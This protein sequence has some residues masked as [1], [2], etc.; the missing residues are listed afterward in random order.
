[1]YGLACLWMLA[2]AAAG[3]AAW[4]DEHVGTVFNCLTRHASA[5]CPAGTCPSVGMSGFMLGE[6]RPALGAAVTYSAPRRRLALQ[7]LP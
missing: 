5:T 6:G 1:M 7:C 3:A 4:W 2:A